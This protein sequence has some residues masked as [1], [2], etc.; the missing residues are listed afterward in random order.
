MNP[1]LGPLFD[2]PQIFTDNDGRHTDAE[3][4]EYRA[5]DVDGELAFEPIT[6]PHFAA[7]RIA[8]RRAGWVRD[9]FDATREAAACWAIE[10][11]ITDI[12]GTGRPATDAELLAVVRA[13][14][15]DDADEDA[16]VQADLARLFAE[17]DQRPVAVERACT[18]GRTVLVRPGLDAA[19]C[20][21][22]IEP[23]EA[24]A[25]GRAHIARAIATGKAA[26]VRR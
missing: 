16:R 22:C 2:T 12:D 20:A 8:E 15:Q 5:V 19:L 1:D 18:C 14:V 4:R 11:A 13:L 6:A 17:R 26:E 7:I 21:D 9:R 3:G 23:Y 24:T 10:L 25:A